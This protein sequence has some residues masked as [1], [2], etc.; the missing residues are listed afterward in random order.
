MDTEVPA[1]AAAKPAQISKDWAAPLL[2][3]PI[4]VHP[5]VFVQVIPVTVRV[6]VFEERIEMHAMRTFPLAGAV[7]VTATGLAVPLPVAC[8][9][10]AV[11]IHLGEL[12]HIEL[13]HAC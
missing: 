6:V 4:F 13:A 7:I 9:T 8:R 10:N 5:L 11:A 3:P 12:L 2:L 1:D